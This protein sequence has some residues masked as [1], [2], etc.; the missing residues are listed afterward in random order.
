M[1][2]Y[3]RMC[4]HKVNMVNEEP[5]TV[6][7]DPDLFIGQ[8]KEQIMEVKV[9]GNARWIYPLMVGD[10][11]VHV[12]LDTGAAA[13]LLA[14]KEYHDLRPRPKLTPVK[15]RL[16]G[17]TGREIEALGACIVRSTVNNKP[18]FIKFIVVRNGSSLL[19]ANTCERLGL[20]SRVNAVECQ[21][22]G[23]A[24]LEQCMLPEVG[25]TTVL[26]TL[27]ISHKNKG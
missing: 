5:G 4:P 21:E 19:G 26:I 1:G 8:V 20:V 17:Y 6:E 18:A 3:A 22:D 25:N 13:N 12:Q 15:V 2:H 9:G 24:E 10:A 23:T 7:G 16:T 27:C 11:T 14:E